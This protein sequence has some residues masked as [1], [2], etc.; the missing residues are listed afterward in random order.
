MS[1]EVRRIEDHNETFPSINREQDP[2]GVTWQRHEVGR[3]DRARIVILS[4]YHI[5][6]LFILV[7]Y[8]LVDT[9]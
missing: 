8:S 5:T 4:D 6:C 1:T 2:Q 9:V 7:L 3:S